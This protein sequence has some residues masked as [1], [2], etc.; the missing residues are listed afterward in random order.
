[1]PFN[2][3]GKCGHLINYRRQWRGIA[4]CQ[5]ADASGQR[6]RDA[7]QFALHAGRQSSHPLVIHNQRPDLRLCEFGVLLVCQFIESC[8]LLSHSTLEFSLT[9]GKSKPS[10][11]HGNF[12]FGFFVVLDLLE[13]GVDL[14]Q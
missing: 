3:R 7:I 4:F 12:V 2:A 14:C 5:F 8:I 13:P 10:L 9:L 11:E 6:L 1:M